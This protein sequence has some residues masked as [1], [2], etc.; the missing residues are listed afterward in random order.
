MR[1]DFKALRILQAQALVASA[2][3]AGFMLAGC[4][5][6]SPEAKG[7]LHVAALG[8]KERAVTFQ[9]LG[10]ILGAKDAKDELD[11]RRFVVAHGN[12]LAADAKALADLV[13]VGT[14]DKQT[15]VLLANLVEVSKA[16]AENW[17][18]ARGKIVVRGMEDAE[19]QAVSQAHAESLLAIAASYS[20]LYES[21][22]DR[23]KSE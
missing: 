10:K 14:V 12:G 2:V 18:A 19:W 5:G 15:K 3:L 11:V 7:L 6:L 20:R 22:R 17:E 1:L 23:G 8:A 16:R 4:G 21:V 9:A 13:A